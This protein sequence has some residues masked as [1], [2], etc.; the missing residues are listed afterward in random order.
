MAWGNKK[1][2]EPA[3]KETKTVQPWELTVP[4][5]EPMK[6]TYFDAIRTE[7]FVNYNVV[8]NF[9][10]FWAA[11]KVDEKADKWRVMHYLVYELDKEDG[12]FVSE[13]AAPKDL[14]FIEAVALLSRN[15]FTASKLQTQADFDMA[16][17]YPADKY[18]ELKAY[19][20]D[21]DYFKDAANI[22]GLAFDEGGMPYRKVQGKVFASATFKRSEVVKSILA[23][24][25]AGNNPRVQEKIEGGIL[26]DIYHT[27]ASPTATLESKLK[28]GQVLSSMDKFNGMVGAFYLGIQQLTGLDDGFDKIEGVQPAEKK[29]FLKTA[30]ATL[31][32]YAGS[33]PSFR[34]LI[35]D[36]LPVMKDELEKTKALGVHVEPF[37]KFTAEC[38]L[39]AN[40][41]YA[42]KNLEALEQSTLSAN[43][44]STSLITQIRESVDRAQA[45]FTELGG[46]Q[47]QMDRLKAWVVNPKK[48]PIP[49]W[50]PGFLTRYYTA[51]GNVMDKIQNRKAGV[52]QLNTMSETVKPGVTSEFNKQAPE[53]EP[54]AQPAAAEQDNAPGKKPDVKTP[55]APGQ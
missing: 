47:E 34:N 7:A 14:S 54:Q 9:V 12:K 46:T 15:E 42:S 52:R 40:L 29:E 5:A 21:L 53:L 20:H 31:A 26:S 41:L 13:P 17:E 3:A 22:E 11:L 19:Y 30:K 10:E 25:Q 39:Y 37:Q 23:V 49:G 1:K 24:E 43:N 6:S 2:D 36:L 4:G 48:D 50:L 45:K 27:A 51:R 18:P 16:T 32:N 44:V 8:E 55:K 33:A 38:E 28:V 35:D